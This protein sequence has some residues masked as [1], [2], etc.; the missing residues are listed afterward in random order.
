MKPVIIILASALLADLICLLLLI[1]NESALTCGS[2]TTK[3]LETMFLIVSVG[4][5]KEVVQEYYDK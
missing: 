2:L 4:L 1:W 5:T 3:L